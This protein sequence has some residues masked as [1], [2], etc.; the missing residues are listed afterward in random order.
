MRK[1]YDAIIG[2]GRDCACSMYLRKNGLQR[3][4]YPFD[5]LTNAA[6][7]KGVLEKRFDL[8]LSDF[9]GF[10]NKN[11]FVPLPK[12]SNEP[13]DS[14][15]NYYEN[16]RTGLRFYHDFKNTS[17]FD[18]QFD[19]VK[20]KYTRRIQRFYQTINSSDQVLLVWFAHQPNISDQEIVGFSDLICKKFTKEIDFVVF[21]NNVDYPVSDTL[22]RV[23]LTENVTKF[24]LN[25]YPS[26]PEHITLGNVRLCNKVF[27]Q[28]TLN[29]TIKQKF[30]YWLTTLR[31]K[32]K[33]KL[34]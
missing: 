28:L 14:N 2:I 10:M 23:A 4:S 31:R 25:T 19:A 18:H 9:D 33:K 6:N 27:K 16:L 8:I 32:L 7:A 21:E 12:N 5:W 11:D 22:E 17:S 34:A 15:H 3:A 30:Q 29:E 24:I 20:Q 13:D 1:R 26:N